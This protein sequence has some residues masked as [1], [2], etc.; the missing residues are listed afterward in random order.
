MLFRHA[1]AVH[2]ASGQRDYDRSLTDRGKRDAAH[3]G[4]LIAAEKFDLALVSSAV[5]TRQTWEAA[6]AQMASPPKAREEKE[7]YLCGARRVVMQIHEVDL[8]VEKLIVVGHNP[9]M[10]EVALWLAGSLENKSVRD[11]RD[12]FPTAAM[13]GFTLDISSWEDIAPKHA[14]LERFVTPRNA[15][16]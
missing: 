7:L 4:S 12:K 2:A 6:S 3:M 5:R 8:S 11:M 13:A 10:Q 15:E 16:D 1:K 9:D 14:M